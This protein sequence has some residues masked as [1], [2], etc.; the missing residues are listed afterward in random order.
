MNSPYEELIDFVVSSGISRTEAE[1]GVRMCALAMAKNGA[2]AYFGTGAVV[3]FM[4]MNPATAVPYL[5][6][7]AAVGAGY[8]LAK[9][10]Q[11]QEVRD[12][13]RYWSAA[14]F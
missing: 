5:V 12:A 6:G 8:G 13:L 2:A 1:H 11:C 9:S 4:S 3:Y 7:A 10:P 14:A